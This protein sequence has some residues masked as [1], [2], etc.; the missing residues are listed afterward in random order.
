MT[1][2]EEVIITPQSDWRFVEG[3]EGNVVRGWHMPTHQW[4]LG[5]GTVLGMIMG[6]LVVSLVWMACL[7][8][9]KAQ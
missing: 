7:D 2:Q 5:V 1:K 3:S 8:M 6:S 4:S 9:L